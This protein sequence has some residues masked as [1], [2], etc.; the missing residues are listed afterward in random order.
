MNEYM[1]SG[2][3]CDLSY[4]GCPG[5]NFPILK[6]FYSETMHVRPQLGKAKIGLTME[7]FFCTVHLFLNN[8]HK[9]NKL[10]PIF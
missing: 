7:Q 10:D 2:K 1:D 8:R 6:S 4:T 3:L 9:T 5:S